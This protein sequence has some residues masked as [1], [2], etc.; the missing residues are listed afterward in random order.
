[1]N[2]D[3]KLRAGDD[4]RA[5]WLLALA[6][7]LCGA[8]YIQT[9]YQTVIAASHA[10]TE[11]LYR[12]TVAEARIV[13]ESS[14]L[15]VIEQRAQSDLAHISH[16]SSLSGTTANLLALLQT[17]AKAFDLR[18][19]EVR[20]GS[21]EDDGTPLRATPVTIG[22]QGQFRDILAFVE[23]LSHQRTLISVTDTEMSVTNES[24]LRGREPRLDATIHAM[25]YR[26][27][28]PQNKEPS[29]AFGE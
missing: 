23:H 12:Q 28:M 16:E 4:V 25:L 10:R 18:V 13:R 29:I 3:L 14:E 17:S 19:R 21:V 6:V 26:L 11:V 20:P 7:L 1:M 27:T 8:F 24:P 15:R 22:V 2:V 9:A 5:V